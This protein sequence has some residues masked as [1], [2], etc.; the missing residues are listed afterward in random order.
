[1]FRI[2]NLHVPKQPHALPHPCSVV[3]SQHPGSHMRFAAVSSLTLNADRLL[4]SSICGAVVLWSSV[5]GPL[6]AVLWCWVAVAAPPP[7]LGF[8]PS[9]LET[10]DALRVKNDSMARYVAQVASTFHHVCYA[11]SFGV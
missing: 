9:A 4:R 10:I 6:L 5:C 2:P 8:T 11:L 3:V 7:D 1:M